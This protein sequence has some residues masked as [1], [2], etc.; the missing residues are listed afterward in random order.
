M[1][2]RCGDCRAVARAVYMMMFGAVQCLRFGA[3]ARGWMRWLFGR[4]GGMVM[5]VSGWGDI[6]DAETELSM[7]SVCTQL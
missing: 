3:R 2:A 1:S 5:K 6:S 4:C 7:R